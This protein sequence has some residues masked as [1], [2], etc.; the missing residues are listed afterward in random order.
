MEGIIVKE[1]KNNGNRLDIDFSVSAGLEKYFLPEHHFFAEYTCDISDVPESVLVV[2]LLTNLLQF[3]WLV[4][5][6]VWVNEI[7][8]TFYD[9][10]PKIKYAFQEMYP[11][12]PFRGTLIP[13]KLIDNTYTPQQSA[14]TLFTGGIDATTTFLRILDQKPILLNTYGWF[15]N[16]I[17]ENEVYNAD[18]T[19]IEK[20][21]D[22]NGVGSCFVRSNFGKFLRADV[23]GKQIHKKIHNSWWFGFQHSLAFIGCAIVAG[24]HY[25]VE[26]I[27]IASS[28][29]FGQNVACVSDPRIDNQVKCAS[30][31]TVHD[32]Y[33]LSRQ[34]K[35]QF[36]LNTLKD[37]PVMVNLRVCS[38]NT[39]NCCSCEK[40]I[41][42]ILS[43]YAEGGN[44][45]DLGFDY[46]GKLTDVVIRFLNTNVME[47]DSA[48]IVFW[49]DI[50][51]RMEE[52][53]DLLPEKDTYNLLKNF[54]YKDAKRKFLLNYYSHNFWRIIKRKLHI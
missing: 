22:A 16:E 30:I 7:D 40:C 38:F 50:I 18:R 27:Y 33:E 46:E 8:K 23:I 19:A 35:V 37:R 53:Y 29:T 47:L 26:K 3:S 5:C 34:S 1:V 15:E 48:H 52:N 10:I 41:R 51:S 31:N 49:R 9:A 45:R 21:A 17:Q 20:I 14:I 42:S 28:Y 54:D 12:Y 32:A 43:I 39:H 11:D 24:Y 25:K 2:P 6:V 36:I 44:A 4:D 13:A